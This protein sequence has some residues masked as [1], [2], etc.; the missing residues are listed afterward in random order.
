METIKPKKERDFI[1]DFAKGIAIILVVLG[2]TFQG[3]A[4]NFDDIYGF[5]IIYSFH[6]PL[7]AFLSGAAASHWV[8]KF[9]IAS[10]FLELT[11]SSIYRINR[12][13]AHLLVPF[14]SW[15]IIS[16]W[17]NNSKELFQEYIIDI[18]RHADR[19]LWFLPCIFW[20]TT[21]TSLFMLFITFIRKAA[22]GTSM[23]ELACHAE[24]L[25]VQMLALLIIWKISEPNLPTELG[26]VF[27]NQFHG[28]LFVFFLLGIVLFKH[29]IKIK[30]VIF[31]VI[32]YVI[33]L[34]LIPYWHRTLPNNLIQDSPEFLT[35]NWLTNKYAMIVAIS[36]TLTAIDIS[37]L[38][39]SIKIIKLNF[40]I[41]Y[42]GTASL[43]IYAIHF[44][45]LK[46]QLHVILTIFISLLIYQLISTIPTAKTLLLGK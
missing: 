38:I 41:Y 27:A 23:D 6:M 25:P 8:T 17:M 12:S 44:Y 24:S 22:S 7:F 35:N 37:R 33:F 39:H 4:N 13:A 46:Y 15:T 18:F 16:F 30:S 10:S 40:L 45:F 5:R 42:I 3:Q 32:P 21:Y 19:S 29:F 2:H 28:G 14:I 34:I 26:L 20:C 11:K 43:G 36:G 1:L 9:T 31:R